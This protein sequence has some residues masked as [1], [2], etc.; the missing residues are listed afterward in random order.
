MLSVRLSAIFSYFWLFS[1][2][3]SFLTNFSVTL[4]KCS[5]QCHIQVHVHF[6]YIQ[7]KFIALYEMF[8]RFEWK[9]PGV[10]F[11][12]YLKDYF[13]SYKIKSSTVLYG[14]LYWS[15][16]FS[17]PVWYSWLSLDLNLCVLVSIFAFISISNYLKI[18]IYFVVFQ[19]GIYFK[20]YNDINP[21]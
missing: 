19:G 17:C 16:F 11:K 12:N 4:S 20:Y 8:P 5:E 3:N 18:L 14:F 13:C 9:A 6:L 2:L 10:S 15:F 7:F 1:Q 21:K